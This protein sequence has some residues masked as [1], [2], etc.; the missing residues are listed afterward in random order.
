VKHKAFNL[1]SIIVPRQEFA[2]LGV[3]HDSLKRQL[4]LSRNRTSPAQYPQVLRFGLDATTPRAPPPT[5]FYW[6]LGEVTLCENG[7]Y[8]A[9]VLQDEIIPCNVEANT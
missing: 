4:P 2:L 6:P 3:Y 7:K 5:E 8:A 9:V 1:L